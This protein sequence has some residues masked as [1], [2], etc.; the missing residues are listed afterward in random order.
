MHMQTGHPTSEEVGC[1]L[2]S[3]IPKRKGFSNTN[4]EILRAT[5]LQIMHR[6]PFSYVPMSGL[7]ELSS[8]LKIVL[9]SAVCS[10]LESLLAV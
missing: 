4:S 1:V 10:T 6:W 3:T 2:Q 9:T 8:H 5:Y 7:A